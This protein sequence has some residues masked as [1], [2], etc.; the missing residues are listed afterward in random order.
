MARGCAAK[1]DA[2][3]RCMAGVI[4]GASALSL[5][6]KVNTH[7]RRIFLKIVAYT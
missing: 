7:V 1:K 4:A 5:A 6:V 3:E 2:I